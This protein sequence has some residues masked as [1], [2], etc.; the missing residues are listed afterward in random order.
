MEKL[1]KLA[2]ADKTI[3]GLTG[4]AGSGKD[5]FFYLLKQKLPFQRFSLADAL[6]EELKN[7]I[8]SK[9]GIDIL[10]CDRNDKNKVR[11]EMVAFAKQKRMETNGTHWYSILHNKIASCSSKYICITDIRHN[12]FPQDEL[13]WLKSILKGRLID[14]SRYNPYSGQV[15][16]PPNSEEAYH[17]PLVKKY[18]DYYVF[19]PEVDTIN[20]LDFFVE[21]AILDLSLK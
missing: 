11:D 14:I 4:L 13:F 12:Y 5:T 18:A 21:K 3:I 1:S 6:K 2:V 9:Y 15:L 10:T 20:N 8:L 17:Y 7:V 19:W 16:L